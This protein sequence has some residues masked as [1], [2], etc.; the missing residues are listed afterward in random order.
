MVYHGY[1]CGTCCPLCAILA[2]S[3]AFLWLRM[4][5]RVRNMWQERMNFTI[6]VTYPISQHQLLRVTFLPQ[7]DNNAP[8]RNGLVCCCFCRLW[9]TSLEC[10]VTLG[11]WQSLTSAFS[12]VEICYER[13]WHGESCNEYVA[14]G[15]LRRSRKEKCGEIWRLL[16][17][18]VYITDLSYMRR[19]GISKTDTFGI[20]R[21]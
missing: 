14:K 9:Q 1:A 18:I 6:C 8:L 11:V 16:F 12:R 4:Q 2:H 17:A 7:Q 19:L 20:N 13:F 10:H 21:Y 5:L 15:I 3:S